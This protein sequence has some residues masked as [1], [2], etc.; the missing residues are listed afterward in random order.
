M[1]DWKN[2]T[3]QELESEANAISFDT[4][5]YA[6]MKRLYPHSD[7]DYVDSDGKSG[8]IL[9]NSIIPYQTSGNEKIYDTRLPWSYVQDE[10]SEY[11]QS[12]LSSIDNVFRGLDLWSWHKARS[13]ANLFLD[14]EGIEDFTS[15]LESAT[16]EEMSLIE[17]KDSENKAKY[18]FSFGV[19]ERRRKMEVG[20]KCIATVNYLNDVNNATDL[21][22]AAQLGDSDISLIMQSL[23]TG[24]L[25]RAKA[26][27]Q[28]K[29]LTGLEPMDQE[30]KD[31]VIELIDDYLG[32]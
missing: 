14:A 18:E 8:E 22:I 12:V 32:A 31:K 24:S 9:Y 1:V 10:E 19:A 17:Q 7:F 30:Y 5:H 20:S 13:S 29:D 25:A 15:M 27:I 21:Q 26:M 28:G 3:K 23:Q 4:H 11:K 6:I 2:K 16:P